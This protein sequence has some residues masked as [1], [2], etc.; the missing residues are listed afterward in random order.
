MKK[1][2]PLAL[3]A[4]IYAP[5]ALAQQVILPA[6]FGDNAVLKQNTQVEIH[7]WAEPTSRVSIVASW[8]PSDTVFA[9]TQNTGKFSTYITTPVGNFTPHTITFN[10]QPLMKNVLIGEV[11]LCSGQSNMQWSVNNGIKDGELHASQANHPTLRIFQMPLCTADV[12]QENCNAL[13]T[14]TTPETMRK[15]S[16]IAYFFGRQLMQ[17]L[18]IP[19]GIIVSAWGGAS[20]EAF[21]PADRIFGSQLLSQNIQ[22]ENNHWRDDRPGKIYNAMIAPLQPYALTGVIWYQGESNVPKWNVYHQLM[23]ALIESWRTNFV[24]QMPFYI[25]Q[26]APFEYGPN[27]N[28]ALL[29][30]AQELVSTTIPNSAMV[31]LSDLVE[32]PNNIHPTDKLTVGQRL[33]SLALADIHNYSIP[34]LYPTFA[35]A[36]F[37][38]AGKAV[39]TFNNIKG[40]LKIGGLQGAPP[41]AEILGLTIVDKQG[42]RHP[43]KG[44]I[45]GNKL[46]VWADGVKDL[47]EVQYCFDNA[48]IGNLFSGEMLPVAPFSSEKKVKF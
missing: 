27:K 16:A 38:T 8:A 44:A 18:D 47:R 12:P 4:L 2:L 33:A 5:I 21:T 11:W 22:T 3:I 48:T 23:K 42:K 46:E 26:I 43:A 25:A 28:A 6:I 36:Q 37:T 15:T 41:L 45:A 35:Q 17:E 29:R 30:Q 34:Y 9:T 31:V 1:I 13:W 39:V 19:V 32:N 7:G 24:Q 20:A 14:L 10:N 40:G